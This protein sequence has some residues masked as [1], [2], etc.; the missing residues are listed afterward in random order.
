MASRLRRI[1]TQG[2]LFAFLGSA[3]AQILWNE[4]V[5]GDLSGDRFNPTNLSFAAGSN[6]IIGSMGLTDKEY[7]HFSLAPGMALAP[8]I[9]VDYSRVDPISFIR[10]QAG[11]TFTEPATGTT[12]GNLLGYTLFGDAHI[13]TDILPAMGTGSGSMGFTPPLTG[14]DYTFRIQQTGD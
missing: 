7:V 13:G 3:H 9:V 2:S 10:V 14:S 11:N 6:R 12:V 8:T 5:N 4:S 1:A